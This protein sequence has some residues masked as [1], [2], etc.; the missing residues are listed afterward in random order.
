MNPDHGPAP[1]P[2]DRVPI[3]P[4]GPQDAI[5]TGGDQGRDA[6][7]RRL[8]AK[9]GFTADLTTYAI[10]NLFLIGV[11]AVTGA[12]YFW[13]IWVML[14]WGVAVA[15]HGWAVF[16]RREITEADIQREMRRGAD[17]TA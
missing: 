16:G 17:P 8:K 4:S 15:M 10:I 12:G 2:Y 5:P 3:D 7:L 1:E 14:G 6:A 11:W 13:P 9:R